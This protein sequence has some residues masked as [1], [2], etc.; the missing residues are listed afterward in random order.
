M[1][2][3]CDIGVSLLK[4]AYC[5]YHPATAIFFTRLSSLCVQTE[6]TDIR[7]EYII[8]FETVWITVD[9]VGFPMHTIPSIVTCL[10]F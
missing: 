10:V 4:L 8:P 5:L 3:K 7:V 6:L 1:H 2:G 9:D